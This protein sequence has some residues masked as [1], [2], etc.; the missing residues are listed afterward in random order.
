MKRLN[1]T[2]GIASGW[3]GE[4]FVM[5]FSGFVLASMVWLGV[6]SFLVKPAHTATLR[7]AEAALKA[8]EDALERCVSTNGQLKALNEKMQLE[9]NGI[10]TKLDEALKGWGRCIKSKQVSEES[11]DTRGA[12]GTR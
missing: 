8:K 2:G 3:A 6:W 4:L 1:E 10:N 12:V 9:I 7:H 5:L 11:V